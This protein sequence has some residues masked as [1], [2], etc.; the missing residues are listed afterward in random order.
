MTTTVL[1]VDDNDDM[2]LML[3]HL[4]GG[5]KDL[6]CV[7]RLDRADALLETIAEKSPKIVLMDLTMPGRN[8]LVVMQ[9]AGPKFPET[10]FVVLSGY[11]DP[12]YIDEA[13]DHG[14][15]GFVSKT[16]D[17][18]AILAAI[19]AVAAGKVSVKHR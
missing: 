17:I 9:E 5:E 18:P 8:P 15:W 13:L 1:I 12:Q 19:R 16:G 10:R 4:V 7:G 11:D 3:Q 14:A 6:A 2:A